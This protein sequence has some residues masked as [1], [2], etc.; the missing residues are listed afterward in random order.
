[1]KDAPFTMFKGVPHDQ[2]RHLYIDYQLPIF[3]CTTFVL[4]V[5]IP[6]RILHMNKY[7]LLYYSGTLSK[8]YLL[9]CLCKKITAKNKKYINHSRFF[10][11]S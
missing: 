3:C 5:G 4:I 10:K 7:L 2:G 8:F 9:S 6:C 11:I 1:M